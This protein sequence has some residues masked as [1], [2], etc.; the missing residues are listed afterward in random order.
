MLMSDVEMLNVPVPDNFVELT[1]RSG[2]EWEISLDRE[3]FLYDFR[4][5]VSLLLKLEKEFVECLL[6]VDV[7]Y[8]PCPTGGMRW[9]YVLHTPDESR[10]YTR[11]SWYT[12]TA[13]IALTQVVPAHQRN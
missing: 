13:D 8:R 4:G 10:V 12:P 2:F 6:Y 11:V 5:D 9:L 1:I 7:F 3:L